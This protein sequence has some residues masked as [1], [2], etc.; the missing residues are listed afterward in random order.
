[1]ID[2]RQTYK[3]AKQ[4]LK[5]KI[6]KLADAEFKHKE[7]IALL[8]R[9]LLS[10]KEKIT[11]HSN[12]SF[13]ETVKTPNKLLFNDSTTHEETSFIKLQFEYRIK[14]VNDLKIITTNKLYYIEVEKA[15][16]NFLL[17]R[18][19]LQ[20]FNLMLMDFIIKGGVFH[21][22]HR[23]G[24]LK[25]IYK[26]RKRLSVDWGQSNKNKQEILDRGGI[27]KH[28][29]QPNGEKWLVFRDSQKS[30]YWFWDKTFVTMKNNA[31]FEFKPTSGQ[32]GSINSLHNYVNANPSVVN[33]YFANTPNKYR[34]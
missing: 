12:M 14:L 30:V 9:E 26:N 1:M 13:K 22:G 17:Y 29:S 4:W 32:V 2:S 24:N 28:I 23:L 7:H 20:G 33:L 31:Y 27:P 18:D 11:K 3:L 15:A 6:T 16:A 25:I 19:I 8:E 34:K 21:I 10:Y 5:N